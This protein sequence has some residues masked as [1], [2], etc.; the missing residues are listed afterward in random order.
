MA[1]DKHGGFFVDRNSERFGL[2]KFLAG[3]ITELQ[4]DRS[5]IE[6]RQMTPVAGDEGQ[7]LSSFLTSIVG[8]DEE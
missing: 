1:D 5:L 4:T 8:R 7:K 6:M 2:I 3:R